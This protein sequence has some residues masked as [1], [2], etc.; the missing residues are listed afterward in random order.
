MDNI[1]LCNISMLDISRL[2][3]WPSVVTSDSVR[4]TL[5]QRLTHPWYLNIWTSHPPHHTFTTHSSLGWRHWTGESKGELENEKNIFWKCW[6]QNEFLNPMNTKSLCLVKA[7]P[8]AAG[9]RLRLAGGEILHSPQRS[10]AP[11]SAANTNK[12]SCRFQ[13]EEK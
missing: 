4:V 13:A 2:W 11:P 7:W 5:I 10:P 1:A 3:H 8:S 12:F 6:N 9:E